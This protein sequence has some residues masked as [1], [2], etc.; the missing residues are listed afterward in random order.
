[1][2]RMKNGMELA[3]TLMRSGLPF[4]VD[5]RTRLASDWVQVCQRVSQSEDG[6]ARWEVVGANREL[7]QA[8]RREI[9]RLTAGFGRG[10]EYRG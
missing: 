4:D 7:V 10:A 9:E 6:L 3:A 2:H 1:M 5:T 8:A